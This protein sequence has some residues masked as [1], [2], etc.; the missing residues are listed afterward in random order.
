MFSVIIPC[1]NEANYIADCL[2]AVARQ[3]G[4]APGHGAEVVVAANGCTDATVA[5]ARAQA[6][7][8]QEAGFA[9]QV[10]DL[11]EPGKV[12]ALNRAEAAAAHP[13]RIF[14]DAD[15]VIGPG[16]LAELAAL[17]AQDAPVYASATVTIPRSPSAVTRA[18]ARIW[19]SLPFVR[20]GVPGIG[21]YAVNA[22]GRRRWGAFPAIYSDDRFVRLH[23][24]PHERR[25]AAATYAWPLPDG[26]RNLVRVRR[27]WSEG[28]REL[29]RLY[30]QL[31][32]NDSERNNNLSNLSALAAAPASATVFLV[33]Y[34]ASEL[35]VRTGRR[36]TGFHWRRGRA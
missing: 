14:L 34:A 2:G 10:L 29:V 13:D 30:P 27:R 3:T 28:N 6:P 32:A 26:L 1:C 25:K 23:F 24:A 12:G 8:L 19:T 7:A 17:L 22:A 9:L 16:V 15:V 21:L 35:L 33:I 11:P 4:L 20:D 18:Y 31:L 36:R 5:I